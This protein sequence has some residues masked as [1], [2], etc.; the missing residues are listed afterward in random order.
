MPSC[1]LRGFPMPVREGIF[2]KKYKN[3]AR[4]MDMWT[5]NPIFA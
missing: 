5:K 2:M 3:D 1:A 4:R